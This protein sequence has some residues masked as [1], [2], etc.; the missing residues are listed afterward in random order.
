MSWMV[1]VDISLL[2]GNMRF[3]I[4]FLIPY[5]LLISDTFPEMIKQRVRSSF[6]RMP[7]YCDSQLVILAYSPFGVIYVQQWTVSWQLTWF[8]NNECYKRS[9]EENNFT[10]NSLPR[11]GENKS[12]YVQDGA[13][14]DCFTNRAILPDKDLSRCM[15]ASEPRRSS[16]TREKYWWNFYIACFISWYW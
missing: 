11:M 9:I 10:V 2:T 16:A 5:T 13:A 7:R 4:C 3:C 15:A 14:R 12:E 8:G 6:R 1:K